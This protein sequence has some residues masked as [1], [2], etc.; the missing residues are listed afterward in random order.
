MSAG[1]PA[2]DLT[3]IQLSDTHILPVGELQHGTVDTFTNLEAALA[4][5]AASRAEVSALLLTGD[6]TDDGSPAAYRRLR[7]LV[8]PAAEELGAHVIYVMGNHDER[9]AFRNE[10]LAEA[11]TGPHDAV[12]W[13]GGVRIVVLDTTTPGQH[14]GRLHPGQLDWLRAELEQPAPRGTVLAL[15]HPPLPSAVPPVHLLRLYDADRL[16]EVVAGT[17][18][19]II[20]SGHNHATG[21]GVL[22]GIPVWV[23]PACANQIDPL[24]KGRLRGVPGGGMT[25]IDVFAESA[26]ATAVP[27]DVASFVYDHDEAQVVKMIHTHL[28]EAE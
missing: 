21:C 25:R 2:P 11:A 3:L 1:V 12:H 27:I 5:V 22:A 13:V 10:L 14:D 15:H 20:L 17:D 19:R 7:E 18:V 16:G 4:T 28:S 23:S 9:T 8:E 26:I 24:V 6:L